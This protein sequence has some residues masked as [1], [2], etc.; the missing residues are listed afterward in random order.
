MSFNLEHPDVA[1]YLGGQVHDGRSSIPKSAACVR[2]AEVLV[3]E[4]VRTNE[5]PR[6]TQHDLLPFVQLILLGTLLYAAGHLQD[7]GVLGLFRAESQQSAFLEGK[8]AISAEVD[9]LRQRLDSAGR[10]RRRHELQ[11]STD[12]DGDV[13]CK[14]LLKTCLAFGCVKRKPQHVRK[15]ESKKVPAELA[16]LNLLQQIRASDRRTIIRF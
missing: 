5:S 6:R 8:P 2:H 15:T 7:Q 9:W 13:R 16:C 11:H 4:R 3:V 12:V 14:G 10:P 1:D